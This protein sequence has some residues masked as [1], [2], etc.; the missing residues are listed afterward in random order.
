M[1]SFK[2]EI[3]NFCLQSYI[4]QVQWEPKNENVFKYKAGIYCTYTVYCQMISRV[5][6]IQPNV[7]TVYHVTTV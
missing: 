4:F 3:N 6:N 7:Y 1:I 5:I 2:K